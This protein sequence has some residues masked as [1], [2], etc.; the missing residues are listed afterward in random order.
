MQVVI[1]LIVFACTGTSVLFI[2]KPIMALIAGTGESSTYFTIL[3]YVLVIPMYNVL[4]LT[5][6]FI[7]GQFRFFWEFEKKT[8][9]RITGKKA[10][11]DPEQN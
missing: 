1:V 6:G 3:Y 11:E 5:Y 7:F 8:W 2:K 10:N 4:L 9:R